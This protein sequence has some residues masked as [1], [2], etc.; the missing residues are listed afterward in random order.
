[1]PLPS[2]TIEP[3]VLSAV[4]SARVAASAVAGGDAGALE[5]GALYAGAL[6][7]GAPVDAAG[8]ALVHPPSNTSDRTG[9]AMTAGQE[10]VTMG[11]SLDSGGLE[12]DTAQAAQRIA[13]LGNPFDAFVR[14]FRC[15]PLLAVR[16]GTRCGA[17]VSAVVG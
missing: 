17:G 1:M 7:G 5:A 12:G 8:A 11:S 4:F 14:I 2:T 10:R 13:D 16:P 3:R 6:E 15:G 9:T